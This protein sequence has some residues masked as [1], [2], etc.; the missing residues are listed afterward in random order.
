MR[1]LFVLIFSAITLFASSVEFK[2]LNAVNSWND[3]I[4]SRDYSAM[5]VLYANKVIYYGKIMPRYKCIADKKRALRK[6]PNF[7]Q[8]IDDLSYKYIMRDIYR[9]SFNKYVR[10][11]IGGK[12]KLYPSYL[13]VDISSVI[14]KIVAESDKV[15]DLNNL[16]R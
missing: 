1:V 5:R 15:T 8:E 16:F 13:Y 14:P 2:L 7:H 9:V 6:R 12:I 3:A 11:K 4:N 10:Y